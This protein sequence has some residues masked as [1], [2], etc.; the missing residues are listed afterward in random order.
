MSAEIKESLRSA[1][2]SLRNA[3]TR[4]KLVMAAYDPTGR[5]TMLQG[6]QASKASRTRI[7]SCCCPMA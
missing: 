5:R 1:W 4:G 6:T 2:S 7:S 3:V